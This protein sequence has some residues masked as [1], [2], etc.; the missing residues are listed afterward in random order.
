MKQKNV[1]GEAPLYP[2]S[3]TEIFYA[4]NPGKCRM[5]PLSADFLKEILDCI[6]KM[7]GDYTQELRKAISELPNSHNNLFLNVK[8]TEFVLLQKDISRL[9]E[10]A[11]SQNRNKEFL[12]ELRRIRGELGDIRIALETFST[13]PFKPKQQTPIYTNDQ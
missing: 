10:E 2:D 3:L 7:E 12:K 5:L 4:Y 11:S 8:V 1:W 9:L 13:K 6:P